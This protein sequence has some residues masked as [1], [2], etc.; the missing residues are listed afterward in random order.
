MTA[1]QGASKQVSLQWSCKIPQGQDTTKLKKTAQW[2]QN[3]T[4]QCESRLRYSAKNDPAVDTFGN[5]KRC[6]TL[7]QLA[8][9]E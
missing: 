1:S 7:N 3:A 2:L 9:I 4:K 6:A 8:R 5:L